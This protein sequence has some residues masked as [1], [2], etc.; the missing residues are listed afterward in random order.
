LARCSAHACKTCRDHRLTR[1]RRG[2]APACRR[3][4]PCIDRQGASFLYAPL[5]GAGPGVELKARLR[6][7]HW[8]RARP[9]C[10]VAYGAKQVCTQRRG[11]TSPVA[12]RTA[13]G[14]VQASLER[15]ERRL[16]RRPASTA[17]LPL[18]RRARAEG[19][20]GTLTTLCSSQY[21]GTLID[22]VALISARVCMCKMSTLP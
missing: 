9:C 18:Q 11:N 10:A 19:V 7:Q 6:H 14:D 22:S 2:E 16:L 4:D 8:T 12:D 21:R 1:Q 20:Y 5:Q 15:A 17:G 3:R 13:S